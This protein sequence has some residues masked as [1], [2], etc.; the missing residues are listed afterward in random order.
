M[1]VVFDVVCAMCGVC[2]VQCV[3]CVWCSVCRVC[4]VCVCLCVVNAYTRLGF[5]LD[6]DLL[7]QK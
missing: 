6:L 3:I 4:G 2:C 1:C 7:G 5:E